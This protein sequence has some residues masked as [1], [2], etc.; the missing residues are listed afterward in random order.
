MNHHQSFFQTQCNRLSLAPG[1]SPVNRHANGERA[2][3]AAFLAPEAV[4]TAVHATP[5][6]HTG[7]KPGANEI[8]PSRRQSACHRVLPMC[9]AA[10]VGFVFT[11]NFGRCEDVITITR[12]VPVLGSTK[13]I[14][15]SLEGFSGEVA[16]ALRFDLAVQGFAFVTPAT[17]QYQISG[18]NNGNVSGRVVDL[19]SKQTKLSRTYNG[20]T[21]AAKPTPLPTTLSGHHRGK[22]RIGGTKIAFKS[23]SQR[24]RRNLRRRFRR[25]RRAARHLRQCDCGQARLGARPFG[26]VLHQLCAATIRTSSITVCP[27]ASG[28]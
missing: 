26:A 20:A 19:I 2:A 6:F 5:V 22:K 16:D 10:L 23:Q 21:N 9:L 7:L 25:P 15:V 18:G 27:P 8:L 17:A 4:E 12:E 11:S 3:S 13:P 1:F 24:Q 28:A 14:P